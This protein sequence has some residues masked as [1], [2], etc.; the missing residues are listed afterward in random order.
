MNIDGG[1]VEW[2][3][4]SK[5]FHINRHSITTLCRLRASRMG[6]ISTKAK[7]FYH[8]NWLIARNQHRSLF[9][10]LF[11][12]VRISPLS[13]S[14][15]PDATRCDGIH[16]EKTLRAKNASSNPSQISRMTF[17][18]NLLL[19]GFSRFFFS[20]SSTCCARC[21]VVVPIMCGCAWDGPH[22]NTIPWEKKEAEK[23][24]KK[25]PK[26]CRHITIHILQPFAEDKGKVHA[27]KWIFC[28]TKGIRHIKILC[29]VLIANCFHFVTYF[30]VCQGWAM[31]VTW[32]VRWEV[33]FKMLA[34][35]SVI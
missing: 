7:S 24:E 32:K 13:S 19:G 8:V 16:E 29:Y 17:T 10:S 35:L 3:W 1:G 5:I 2:I 22:K 30:W 12:V 11:F 26:N 4:H 9:M 21:F 28:D 27:H 6:Q 14:F 33:E 15:H 34:K 20:F 18:E 23:N 31:F 25:D